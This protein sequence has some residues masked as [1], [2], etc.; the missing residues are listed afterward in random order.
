MNKGMK[1][2]LAFGAIGILILLALMILIPFLFKGKIKDAVIAAANENLNAKVEIEDFGLNLFSNFPSATLSLKDVRIIGIDEFE[3][4]TLV[5]SKKASVSIN[6]MS[7]F[8]DNYDISKIEI[9]NTNILAK[10]NKGGKVNWDI[11]KE[12]PK[13]SA[14]ES[15]ELNSPFNLELKD[16]VIKNTNIIYEDL[17][18]NMKAYIMGWNGNI[19]GDFSASETTLK[20][21]S[22]I[23][24]L[25]FVSDGIPYLSK[26]KAVADAKVNANFDTMKF[27][28]EDSNF[29]LNDLSASADGS[30]TYV[31]EEQMDFDLRLNAPDVDFKQILSLVPAIYSED[32]KNVQASGDVSLKASAIGAMKMEK[33][34]YP[35]IDLQLLVKDGTFKYPSLPKSVDHINIDLSVNGN[36]GPLENV[37]VQ[38]SH[39]GFTLGGNPFKGSFKSAPTIKD[40]SITLNAEGKLDLAMI[41]DVYPLGDDTKLNGSLDAKIHVATTM[42]A[43]E[44]E[45]YENTSADGYLKVSKMEY[46]ATDIPEVLINTANME[47][48][49]KYINLSALDLTLGKSDIEA[50]GRLENFIAYALK[51]QTLKGNLNVKSKYLNIDE[52]M[53]KSSATETKQE[54]K[55]S[56]ENV[57]IPKN[58]DFSLD[59]QFQ[60][61]VFSSIDLKAVSGGL[62]IK[63]GILA[64]KNIKANTLGGNANINGNYNTSNPQT[65]L[66][67]FNLDLNKMSFAETFKQIE[68]VQKFAPIFQDVQGTYSMNFKMNT[69][70]GNTSAETLQN[71]TAKGVLTTN[72]V[73][74]EGNKA[75]SALGKA[76]KTDKLDKISTNNLKLGFDIEDGKL[77]TDPFNFNF[78]DGGQMTLEGVTK[79]DQSIDYKGTVKLPTSL[80]NKYVNKVPLN[81]KGTFTDP[82]VEVDLKAAV[83][84]ALSSA[85]GGFFGKEGENTTTDDVKNKISEETEKQ[86]A[87]IRNEADKAAKELIDTAKKAAEEAEAKAKNPLTK[88]AAK[89]LGEETVK[90]AEKEAQNLK[91]KVE[92]KIKELSSDKK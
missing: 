12:D 41:K 69:K 24:E 77:I 26:I 63:D 35:A 5:N 64:M 43:I 27:T 86:I 89:K 39:F 65:P 87:K 48:T 4:D 2:G 28:F 3:E 14:S 15:E 85:V 76:L 47:F 22:V 91:D 45:Q 17:D 51:D 55:E 72:E 75:L 59:A 6:L 32:F 20:T 60:H 30:V 83:T 56:T 71:L 42:S 25:T 90:Q 79:L 68:A 18:G 53:G 88:A 66:V 34:I 82:K 40:R 70:L 31:N 78:G 80:E 54:S 33:D 38:V 16:I 67:D 29:K 57:I 37:I 46:K 81:I 7:L 8:G 10:V 49:P 58:I 11:V 50:T 36:E 74:L 61:I 52:L 44:K 84:G 62:T 23:N 19:K 21:K 13:A 9:D 92:E 73:K 1:K